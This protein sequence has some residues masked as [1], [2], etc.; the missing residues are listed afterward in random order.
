MPY[1]ATGTNWKILPPGVF[2]QTTGRRPAG[3]RSHRLHRA[4]DAKFL[5]GAVMNSPYGKTIEEA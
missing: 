3:R 5:Y 1:S 4:D 2:R